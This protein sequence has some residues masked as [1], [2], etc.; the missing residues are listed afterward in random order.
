M[1]N[2]NC[3]INQGTIFSKLLT[4]KLNKKKSQKMEKK[5]DFFSLRKS[6]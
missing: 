3:I 1:Q 5:E 6:F 2:E 4:T